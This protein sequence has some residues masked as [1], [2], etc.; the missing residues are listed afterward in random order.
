MKKGWVAILAFLYIT[1][2]SGIVVNLHYCMGDLAT[3]E[4]GLNHDDTCG[5]CGMKDRK[6]CC[7]TQY[8]VVKVQDAHQAAKDL[9]SGFKAVPALA[10]SVY[11]EPFVAVEAAA[12]A[13]YEAYTPPDTGTN[14]RYIAICVFRI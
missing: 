11:A 3:V 14:D 10:A 8:Q 13:A 1:L 12:A 9:Q 5:K 6:G 2:S 7:E 4:L